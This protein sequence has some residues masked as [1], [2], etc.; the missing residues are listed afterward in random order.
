MNGYI[1]LADSVVGDKFFD[2]SLDLLV[3]VVEAAA[4]FGGEYYVLHCL[5]LCGRAGETNLLGVGFYVCC[6]PFGYVKLGVGCKAGCCCFAE[7][8][9]F[10]G[11]CCI[12]VFHQALG[13]A[14]AT[15]C[16][17][18]VYGHNAGQGSDYG[19]DT[20]FEA[21]FYG[22]FAVLHF[23]DVFCVCHLG[24]TELFCNL[25]AYLSGIA[26]DS[27]AAAEEDRKSVA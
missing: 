21:T 14:G 18:A 24:N 22:H 19:L 17:R 20:V 3:V 27:L 4:F 1:D 13:V 12:F 15:F 25:G 7:R 11:R 5:N 2:K 10:G 8:C 9:G 6:A 16:G 26:V 23:E